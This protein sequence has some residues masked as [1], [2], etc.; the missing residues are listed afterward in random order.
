MAVQRHHQE[1]PATTPCPPCE[2]IDFPHVPFW[3]R[4][5]WTNY[6]EEEGERSR[7][8][9]VGMYLTNE[10]GK[11]LSKDQMDEI[12]ITAKAAWVQL[13]LAN[14]MPDSWRYLSQVAAEY[15]YNIILATHPE[16][17]YAD[18]PWK[19]RAYATTYY[20]N[21][22]RTHGHKYAPGLRASEE[23]RAASPG[24]FCFQHM[25]NITD[26]VCRYL[27][28][29]EEAEIRWQPANGE[30]ADQTP[31]RYQCCYHQLKTW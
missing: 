18:G 8:I 9:P 5:S 21:W 28:P 6:V 26:D 1:L 12:G 3:S 7:K 14:Y 25:A 27:S 24:Q 4:G 15:F 16:F 29:L 10:Q 31:P 30:E 19:A 17:S 11:Q 23:P 2:K 13:A 20:P 22:K